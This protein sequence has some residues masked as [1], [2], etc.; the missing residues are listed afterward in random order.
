MYLVDANVLI[1]AKNRY[2]AFDIAPGFWEWVHEA[3]Q[4]GLVGSIEAVRNELLRGDD[5]LA[6]WAR[7]HTTFF[8]PIDQATAQHFAPLSQWASSRNFTSAALTGFTGDHA[9]FQLVAH[10]RAHGHTV[11][12]H[13]RSSPHSRKRVLI[14]DACMAMDVSTSDTFQMLRATG[15]RLGL[16]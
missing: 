6:D 13:E 3:H 8:R 2:Y 16:L 15:A 7:V 12:T 14:P 1:E 4:N 5:D 9:D 11:V 10:A